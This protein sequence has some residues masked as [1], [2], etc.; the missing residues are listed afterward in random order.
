MSRPLEEIQELLRFSDI[1]A[2]AA[3]AALLEEDLLQLEDI[4]IYAKGLFERPNARDILETSIKPAGKDKEDALHLYLSRE[5]LYDGLPEAL[6]HQARGRRGFKDL[7]EMLTESKLQRQEEQEA[8]TFFLPF[9]QEF[10]RKRIQIEQ[11]ERSVLFQMGPKLLGRLFRDRID[12]ESQLDE[13]Q[14]LYY[15]LPLAHRIAGDLKLTMECFSMILLEEVI[16]RE[17]PPKMIRL[18][19]QEVPGIG[20]TVLGKNMV[21]GQ[22]VPSE[23]RHFLIHV[24]PV[25]AK[26]LPLFLEG[27]RKWKLLQL[28]VNSFLPVEYETTIEIVAKKGEAF[29]LTEESTGAYLGY[30]TI[31]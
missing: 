3:L 11:N 4:I 27:G 26:S 15:L 1:K 7:E 8:R 17:L 10:F 24:G 14:K 21:I 22:E 9:E 23:S 16:I 13:K 12:Q 2:E 5:G 19:D 29:Y 30:S 28:L 20:E 25:K 31:L 6:F 18:S